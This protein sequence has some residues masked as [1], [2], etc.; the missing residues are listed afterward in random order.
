M[1]IWLGSTTSIDSNDLSLKD[2][3]LH[4]VADPDNVKKEGVYVYYK[5]NLAIH[6][7]TGK[8]KPMIAS[9]VTFKNKKVI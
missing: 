7:F 6:F 4:C 2:H 3:N 8:V 1:E 5:E 9:E